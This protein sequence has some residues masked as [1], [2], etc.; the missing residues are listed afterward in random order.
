MLVRDAAVSLWTDCEISCLVFLFAA[1][2]KV[3]VSFEVKVSS[4]KGQVGESGSLRVLI[5]H[6]RFFPLPLLKFLF[7]SPLFHPRSSLPGLPHYLR[8]H[9]QDWQ[10][11]CRWVLAGLHG[12]AGG[13]GAGCVVWASS[14]LPGNW[15][16]SGQ[17]ICQCQPNTVLPAGIS[18]EVRLVYA[19]LKAVLESP[20]CLFPTCPLLSRQAETSTSY[21]FHSLLYNRNEHRSRS[22]LRNSLTSL[23]RSAGLWN[24]AVCQ[25]SCRQ[26]FS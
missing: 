8:C 3:G 17:P 23:F 18:D 25:K 16:C 1:F 24:G 4:S 9:P 6:L 2:Q 15:A 20:Q 21:V 26:L 5:Y 10:S 13:S 14:R 22:G 11:P 7:F 19:T 12:W